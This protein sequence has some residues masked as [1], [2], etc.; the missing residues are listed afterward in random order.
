MIY[1]EI[2]LKVLALQLCGHLGTR[3]NFWKN[4][5]T[6][7]AIDALLRTNPDVIEKMKELTNR[8]ENDSSA[9]D[10]FICIFD[11]NFPCI[12]SKSS[13]GEKPYLLFYRGDTQLLSDL[14]QNVAVIGLVDPTENIEK[15]ERMVVDNLIEQGLVIVSGLAQGC[16]T[17]AHRVCVERKARTIAIL[18]SPLNAIVPAS[19]QMLAEEIVDAGGLLLTEY[20]RG[21]TNHY[22]AINRFVERDRLQAMFSKAVILISSYAKDVGDSGSRHAMEK[23]KKYGHHRYILYNQ[24]TDLNDA[25]FGLNRQLFD[26]E[27]VPPLTGNIIKNIKE[28]KVNELSRKFV[29]TT[30][31][32][33]SMLDL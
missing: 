16:D 8:F 1:S 11:D 3:A 17:I 29:V 5:A 20:F 6:K 31:V 13:S 12:T 25:Q 26:D 10:G 19:N 14:N 18:P 21:T 30:C 22:E 28:L 24:E 23:A 2:A 33:T 4:H 27:K 15:R 32:Q 7:N 9:M